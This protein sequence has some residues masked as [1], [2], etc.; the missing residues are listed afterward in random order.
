MRSNDNTPTAL[1]TLRMTDESY[2]YDSNWDIP[3]KAALRATWVLLLLMG[4]GFAASL[5]LFLK[6]RSASHDENLNTLQGRI[7]DPVG[8]RCEYP[9]QYILKSRLLL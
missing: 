8:I 9:S 4:T 7:V 3:C 6:Y 2:E 5:V 1:Y